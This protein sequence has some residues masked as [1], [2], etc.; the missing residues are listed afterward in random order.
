M[1]LHIHV[2]VYIQMNIYTYIRVYKYLHVYICT[3]IFDYTYLYIHLHVLNIGTRCSISTHHCGQ[4]DGVHEIG[5]N[6]PGTRG[7]IKGCVIARG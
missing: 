5:G 6:C 3:L 4:N 7:T 1:Y 2:Y